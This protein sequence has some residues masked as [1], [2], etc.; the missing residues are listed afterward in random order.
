MPRSRQW[1]DL[2]QIWF[3]GSSRGRNQL[4]LILLQLAHGFRFCEGSKFAISH[5]LGR[6][7]LTQCWRYRAACDNHVTPQID[8]L[9][10]PDI[11]HSDVHFS[12]DLVSRAIN[13]LKAKNSSGPDG[14]S[15]FIKHLANSISLPLTLLFATSFTT[16]TVPAIWRTATVTPVFKQVYRR[17]YESRR[18]SKP[19]LQ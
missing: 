14:S 8:K 11:E 1:I 3:R 18:S 7:P 16:G 15:D 6:S 12:P 9:V 10:D 17:R 4:C 13:Q 19:K 2:Y 5:W